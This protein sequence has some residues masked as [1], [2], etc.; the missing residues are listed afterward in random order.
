MKEAKEGA[1]GVAFE[2]EL[3]VLA[4]CALGAGPLEQHAGHAIPVIGPDGVGLHCYVGGC[5]KGQQ[6]QRILMS[7]FK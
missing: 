5:L 3:A 7:F 6:E 2:S 4:R 1:R